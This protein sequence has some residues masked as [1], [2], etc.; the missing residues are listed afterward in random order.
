MYVIHVCDMFFLQLD[1]SMYVL[2]QTIFF[3]QND[4][5]NKHS[6][7]YIYVSYTI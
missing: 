1:S 4:F 2:V 5:P 7:L 6:L 3:V